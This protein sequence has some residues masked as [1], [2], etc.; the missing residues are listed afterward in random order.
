MD[1]RDDL[2][3][4]VVGYGMAGRDFHAPLIGRVPGLRVTQVVTGDQVRADAARAEIDGVQVVADTEALWVGADEIDL[5]VL[6][7]PTA[8]HAA[9]ATEAVRRG[10][11]VVVDKPLAVNAPEARAVADLAAGAGV[12]L[13]VF[14]NRRWDPEHRTAREVLASGVLGDVVRYEARYE[15][16]RPVPKQRWRE[17]SVSAD[18]GGVLMDLQSH[19]VD[20]ALDLFG[21]VATV[22]AQLAAFT[23]VGDDVA[24]LALQHVCGVV[25]HLGTTSLAAAPGP[26]T[27][28]LGTR[29]AYLVA[30]VDDDPTA[31]SSWADPDDDHR[32]WLVRGEQAEPVPRAPGEWADFYV[33]V[34]DAL[35]TGSAPPVLAADGVAVIEVLDAARRS[36]AGNEVVTLAP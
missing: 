34:R 3:V 20:G 33:G 16:W 2:R 18:G 28:L 30:G 13:S 9:Q 29:A 8:V 4:A 11:P 19:L 15:R 1:D 5:V 36:A 23:T 24:F 25:S 17:Q 14:H 7:S 31:L 22:Y 27:R 12:L 10:L 26:R 32:G 35:L 21:P 6:A